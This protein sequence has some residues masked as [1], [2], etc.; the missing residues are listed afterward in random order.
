VKCYLGK[1]K[2]GAAWRIQIKVT[3]HAGHRTVRDKA[4]VTSVTPDPRLGNNTATAH[5]KITR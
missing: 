5:T 1:L 3:V 2:T 4:N